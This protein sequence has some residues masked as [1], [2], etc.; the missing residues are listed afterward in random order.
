MGRTVGLRR[1]RDCERDLD[2]VVL[3]FVRVLS[4]WEGWALGEALRLP[5]LLVALSTLSLSSVL[6]LLLIPLLRGLRLGLISD[7]T[8]VSVDFLLGD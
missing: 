2:G 4:L 3:V 6:L 8:V 5:R 1:D 7:V